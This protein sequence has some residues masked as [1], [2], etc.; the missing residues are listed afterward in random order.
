MV[1]PDYRDEP[2]YSDVILTWGELTGATKQQRG[3]AAGA[4][5]FLQGRRAGCLDDAAGHLGLAAGRLDAA[6]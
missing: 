6:P 2:D 1:E 3:P 5:A 4:S